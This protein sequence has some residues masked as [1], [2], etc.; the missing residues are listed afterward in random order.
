MALTIK[1]IPNPRGGVMNRSFTQFG[2]MWYV[3]N[4]AKWGIS[5]PRTGEDTNS[6]KYVI[7]GDMN[8]GGYPASKI[9]NANQFGR[10]GTFFIIQ[11]E[12]LHD[13]QSGRE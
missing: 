13:S 2:K 8:G 6:P 1:D 7:L 11:S 4:H 3:G 5:T 9:C 10:G 12:E